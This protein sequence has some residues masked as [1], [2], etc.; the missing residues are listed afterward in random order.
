MAGKDSVFSCVSSKKTVFN[1]QSLRQPYFD[2][3]LRQGKRGEKC[4]FAPSHAYFVFFA[5]TMTDT[6]CDTWALYCLPCSAT[7]SLIYFFTF[8][9]VRRWEWWSVIADSTE[10]YSCGRLCG[11][12]LIT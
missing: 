2:Y 3:I 1:L 12:N 4:A 5:D 8:V 11:G 6:D 10:F 7:H 9:P